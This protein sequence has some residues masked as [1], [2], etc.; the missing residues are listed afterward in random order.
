M[1]NVQYIDTYRTGGRSWK[2][3]SVNAANAAHVVAKAAA[4]NKGAKRLRRG[5]IKGRVQAGKIHP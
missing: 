2:T 1:L 3:I 4:K 5:R